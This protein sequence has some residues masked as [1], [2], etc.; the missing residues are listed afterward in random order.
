MHMIKKNYSYYLIFDTKQYRFVTPCKVIHCVKILS[1]NFY[2]LNYETEELT[3]LF[4]ETGE[5]RPVRQIAYRYNF[6]CP[7]VGCSNSVFLMPHDKFPGIHRM[8]H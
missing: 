2:F 6:A 4:I 3:P 7:L 1:W 5:Y 8:A